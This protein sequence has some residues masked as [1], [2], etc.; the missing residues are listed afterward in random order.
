MSHAVLDENANTLFLT[1]MVRGLGMTLKVF[2][3]TPVT[4]C[5]DPSI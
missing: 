4:V 5:L 1:E 3:D 2:F